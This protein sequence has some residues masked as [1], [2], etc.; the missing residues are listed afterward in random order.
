M[1]EHFMRLFKLNFT[2][3]VDLSNLISRKVFLRFALGLQLL[4]NHRQILAG[5]FMGRH[6][7]RRRKGIL[8]KRNV[9]MDY[10]EVFGWF[11]KVNSAELIVWRLN[12]IGLEA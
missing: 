7:E 11:R 8:R 4:L 10:L 1:V 6:F 9:F 12:R 5:I 2:F 3:F